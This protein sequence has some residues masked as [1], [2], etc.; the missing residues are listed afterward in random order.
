MK[1]VKQSVPKHTRESEHADP[2]ELHNPV[3]KVI[4]GLIAGLVIWA[5]YYIF[6]ADPTAVSSLGDH[7][8]PSE[9]VSNNKAGE[10]GVIDGRQIFVSTCQACHQATGQGLPGVFPPLAGSSFVTGDPHILTQIV[11]HGLHGPIEVSGTTYNGS[12]PAFGTQFNDG[13]L[14]ALLSFIRKEWGNTGAP[15]EAGLV[16]DSRAATAKRTDPWPSIKE[17]EAAVGGIAKPAD[18]KS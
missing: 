7:R 13:Q 1:S 14:A 10:G 16:K 8:V 2:S 3:P 4:I 18:A 17:I 6:M 12:M 9:L 15:V 5:V 11:L